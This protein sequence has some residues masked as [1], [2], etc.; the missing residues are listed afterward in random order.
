MVDSPR[1]A[2]WERGAASRPSQEAEGGRG[3]PPACSGMPAGAAPT[4]RLPAEPAASPSEPDGL[5]GLYAAFERQVQVSAAPPSVFDKLS[6]QSSWTGRARYGAAG[7]DA[8]DGAHGLAASLRPQL[9]QSGRGGGASSSGGATRKASPPPWNSPGRRHSG[10]GS[11]PVRPAS[12]PPSA[13]PG[14]ARATSSQAL[15]RLAQP[16]SK[17]RSPRG[18]AAAASPERAGARGSA[19][20]VAGGRREGYRDVGTRMLERHAKK[21]MEME[22]IRAAVKRQREAE[23]QA[24]CKP[25]NRPGARVQKADKSRPAFER[26][27]E[28]GKEKEKR[29]IAE[30]DRRRKQVEEQEE[31]ARTPPRAEAKRKKTP[32]SRALAARR[33]T[34]S[35]DGKQRQRATPPAEAAAAIVAE[36]TVVEADSLLVVEPDI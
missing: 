10:G 17:S 5:E 16:K 14:S 22:E 2:H 23:E 12:T 9:H 21:Q 28:W 1:L 18:G 7:A 36:A 29:L 3:A 15:S 32:R 31:Q 30:R 4:P 8:R 11:S 25:R 27:C 24:L 13:A 35:A 33:S 26:C 6:E 20:P 34:G 19:S